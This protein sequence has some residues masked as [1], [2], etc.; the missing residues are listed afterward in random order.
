M[1]VVH[2]DPGRNF[3][4]RERI[5]GGFCFRQCACLLP[6]LQQIK[7]AKGTLPYFELLLQSNSMNG[8][9]SQSEIVA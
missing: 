3:Q 4:G 5:G 9:A 1:T 8:S 2:T 6:F 7:S